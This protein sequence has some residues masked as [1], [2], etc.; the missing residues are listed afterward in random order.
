M[1]FLLVLFRS[2]RKSTRLNS[3][4][5][6]ISYAAFC[7]QKSPPPLALTSTPAAAAPAP[8]P[9][10]PRPACGGAPRGAGRGRR[11]GALDCAELVR[12]FAEVGRPRD[13]DR[14]PRPGRLRG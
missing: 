1:P 9:P 11:R 2:D 5:T 10:A 7:L 4:H 3:S 8:R 14:P 13:D 12:F 6:I